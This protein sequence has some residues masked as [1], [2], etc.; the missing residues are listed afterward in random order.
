MAM[1]LSLQ[2]FIGERRKL[3]TGN[4]AVRKRLNKDF[5]PLFVR[6]RAKNRTEPAVVGHKASVEY[7]N[8]RRNVR[9]DASPQTI[10]VAGQSCG[11]IPCPPSISPWLCVRGRGGPSTMTPRIGHFLTRLKLVSCLKGCPLN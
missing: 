4:F 6:K 2:L 3:D 8:W 1:Y 5:E 11:G 9:H 7:G 10:F